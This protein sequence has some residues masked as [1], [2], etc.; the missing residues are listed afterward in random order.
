MLPGAPSSGPRGRVQ[1][2]SW[3]EGSGL[4]A[5]HSAVTQSPGPSITVELQDQLC[6]KGRPGYGCFRYPQGQDR[7]SALGLAL[8]EV[9]WARLKVPCQMHIDPL[10]GVMQPVQGFFSLQP[11]L[12]ISPAVTGAQCQAVLLGRAGKVAL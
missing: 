6:S 11:Q 9:P 10:L 5:S 8:A 4:L 1:L 7:G 3:P 12:D 2:V